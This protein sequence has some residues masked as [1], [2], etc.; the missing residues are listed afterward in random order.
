MTRRLGAA[1]LFLALAM[2]AIASPPKLEGIAYTQ[3]TGNTLPRTATLLDEHGAAVTLSDISRGKPLVLVLGY[4]HCPNLCGIVRADLF[5]ALQK[6]DLV[7]G[8]DYQL[9]S[10]SIDPAET[11]RDAATAKAQDIVRFPAPGAEGGWHFLTGQPAAVQMIADAVGFGNRPDPRQS[12]PP[13][14]INQRNQFLHP[15]GVVFVTPSGVISSYLLG[16]GY[17]PAD[18]RLAVTR[19]ERGTIQAAALPILLLC[20][21][22]DESTGHY[23]L[24]IMKL[25]RLAAVLTVLTLG[26]TLLLAF[27]RGRGPA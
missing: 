8:R 27:R 15:T 19:A 5:H 9:V 22:Y 21:D 11:P 2:P 16:V 3:R 6:S 13:A 20:Y 17:Q 24:A 23:T 4:F 1:L 25:L 7:G 14:G 10:L 26:T 12:V 18:V